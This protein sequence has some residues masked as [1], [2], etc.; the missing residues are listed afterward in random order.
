MIASDDANPQFAGAT[1]PDARLYV[2]FYIKPLENSFQTAKQG[3]PVFDDTEFVHIEVPGN[4]LSI[5]DTIANDSHRQQFPLQY[6]RFKNENAVEQ[7]SGLPV[8]HWTQVTRSQAE[9]LKALKFRTVEQIAEASD[10][11]I[12]SVGMVGGMDPMAFRAKA[13]RFLMAAQGTADLEAKAAEEEAA[14]KRIAELEEQVRKLTEIA[15][16]PEPAKKR[17]GMPKGG[18]PKKE[19]RA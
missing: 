10:A 16:A 11:Q 13:K 3:R 4:R 15:M 7:T 14:K 17:R 19:A 8:E 6:A 1:N 9:M 12:Q 5:I 2:R 18:W